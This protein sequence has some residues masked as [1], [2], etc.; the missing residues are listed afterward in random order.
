MRRGFYLR[1]YSFPEGELT[2]VTIIYRSLPFA[3]M[4]NKAPSLTSLAETI[5]QTSA[6]LAS[7][8][9]KDGHTAPS[10]AEDGLVDYPKSPEILGIR[11][12]L[13]DAAADMYRLALGPTDASFLGPIFVR[14]PRS[15]TEV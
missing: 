14:P 10:F 3:K 2:N 4:T 13:L 15:P 7:K 11:M 6:A 9:A 1:W 8:L 5:S 12:Q